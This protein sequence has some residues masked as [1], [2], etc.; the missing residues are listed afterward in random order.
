MHNRQRLPEGDR[1]V[2][3][4]RVF[5]HWLKRTGKALDSEKHKV[6]ALSRSQQ[7]IWNLEQAYPG[8]SI[9]HISTTVSIRGR[10]DFA[11]LQESIRLVLKADATLR[12]RITLQDGKPVQYF[13]PCGEERFDIYDFSHTD[14]EGIE[15]W[16]TA[17]SREA[18]PVLDAPLYRFALFGAGENTGG[19]FL[20]IH[21]I[22]WDQP[23]EMI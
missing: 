22:I 16:E 8:T 6:F 12:T 15:S 21:H 4:A 23:S 14:Q 19:I 9:N 11:L 10:I 3:G 7:N 18:L 17:M 2:T 20:K 1:G 5:R 13:A